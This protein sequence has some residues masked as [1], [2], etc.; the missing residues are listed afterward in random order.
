MGIETKILD[1]TGVQRTGFIRFS[2][3]VQNFFGSDQPAFSRNRPDG[4]SPMNDIVPELV[5]VQCARENAGRADHGDDWEAMTVHKQSGG[6][7][8]R[9]VGDART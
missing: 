3:W 5:K 8:I 1:Q 6:E 4:A 2:R 9:P 7:G